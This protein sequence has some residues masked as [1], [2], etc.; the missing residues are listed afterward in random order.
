MSNTIEELRAKVEKND[1][2]VDLRIEFGVAL[3]EELCYEEAARQFQ[4]AVELTP[5]RADGHYN[6]GV[7]FGQFLLIILHLIKQAL[8]ELQS[9]ELLFLLSHLP[10]L[11]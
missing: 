6:L 1:N 7:L 5:S 4:K 2:D 9:E 8:S 3:A 10:N 11:I